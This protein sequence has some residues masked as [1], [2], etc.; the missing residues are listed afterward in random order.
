MPL[1]DARDLEL[2]GLAA[3]RVVQVGDLAAGPPDGGTYV[4]LVGAAGIAEAK[5]LAGFEVESAWIVTV[6][7]CVVGRIGPVAGGH[8]DRDRARDSRRREVPARRSGCP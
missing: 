2:E 8:R 4:T 3:G 7:V 5:G 1:C 6:N